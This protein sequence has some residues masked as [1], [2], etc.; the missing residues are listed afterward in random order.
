MGI[1]TEDRLLHHRAI[2]LDFARNRAPFVIADM[3]DS[4][5]LSGAI[6]SVRVS[7]NENAT[8]KLN[9]L[10]SENNDNPELFS[11]YF[12][13]HSVI[14]T[15]I[16]DP[17]YKFDYWLINGERYYDS[18]ITLSYSMFGQE[19]NAQ[20]IVSVDETFSSIVIGQIYIG[21]YDDGYI[22]LSNITNRYIE[23]IVY[24]SNRLRN[25]NIHRVQFNIAPHSS[26]TLLESELPFNWSARDTL[27]FSDDTGVFAQ[28]RLPDM[29]SCEILSRRPNGQ[30]RVTR[31][32]NLG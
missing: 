4:F 29:S 28:F 26:M 14:L 17:G 23:G 20:A 2:I 16:P 8:V 32:E 11:T 18:V 6:Y 7:G 27:Y 10:V 30:H 22:V 25:L 24:I 19:I 9:T 15:C 5:G 1:F 3:V 31:T 21:Q 12:I 13:E